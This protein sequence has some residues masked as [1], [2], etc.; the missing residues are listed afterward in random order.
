MIHMSCIQTAGGPFSYKAVDFKK[1]LI[2]I[3]TECS[4]FVIQ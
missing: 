2:I 1:T 3:I 4:V